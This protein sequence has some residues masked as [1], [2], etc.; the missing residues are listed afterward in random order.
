MTSPTPS[1]SRTRLLGDWGTSRL[2]LWLARDGVIAPWREGPGIGALDRPAELVLRDV[3]SELPA[4]QKPSSIVLCGMAGARGGLREAPYADCPADR[5]AWAR[6]AMRCTFEGVPLA[7][8]P[9]VATPSSSPHAD[10]M[11]GEETQIFGAIARDPALATGRQTLLLPGTH[12]K[13]VEIED[14]AITGFRT[15][16][17][18]ELYALLGRSTLLAAGVEGEDGE[19][20]FIAGL[21]K[22]RAGGVLGALF[23]AR[24]AQLRAHRS[25]AWAAGFLSGLLIGG[26]IAEVAARGS[27]PAYIP[28]IGDARLANRYTQAL[29][30]YRITAQI[31]DVETVTLAGLSLMIL[32]STDAND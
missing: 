14:G 30:S 22:A 16:F 24:A 8:A 17:T 10:V 32:E 25:G 11:R 1:S 29:T 20:G 18:G 26:E 5:T 28:L 27:L 23:Q 9:G 15:F 19:E 6:Q 13:W 31:L 7:I 2:R 21:E 3:L 12:S 4:D